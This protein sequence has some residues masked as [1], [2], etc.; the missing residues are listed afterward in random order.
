MRR[1]DIERYRSEWFAGD[2]R[3]WYEAALEETPD[4][5]AP[6]NG[7]G[8]LA[9]REGHWVTAAYRYALAATAP[10]PFPAA[11]NFRKAFKRCDTFPPTKRLLFEYA[12]C[13]RYAKLLVGD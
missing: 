6:Q 12:V 11:S 3:S 4:D 13:Q 1:G 10:R 9:A 8:L 5:G 7:L 2:A